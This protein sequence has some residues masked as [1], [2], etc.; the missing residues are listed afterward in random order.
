MKTGYDNSKLSSYTYIIEK[1]VIVLSPVDDPTASLASGDSVLANTPVTLSCNTTGA[2]IYYTTD[3]TTPSS[4]VGQLY[5]K[6]IIVTKDVTI[7]AI[8]VKSGYSDSKVVTFVYLLKKPTDLTNAGKQSSNYLTV[9]PNPSAESQKMIVK[10]EKNH[11]MLLNNSELVIS[12]VN[13]NIVKVIPVN[14]SILD[15][16]GLKTGIYFITL[17]MQDKI[18]QGDVKII[19]E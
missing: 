6:L 19:V 15:I 11:E 10:I 16:T 2:S 4:T 12:S 9:Y 8:A 13:G 7:K 5:S 3:G 1:P 18:I 14:N 17:Q